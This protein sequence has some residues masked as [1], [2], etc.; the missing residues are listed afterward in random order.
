[1]C[2]V[3]DESGAQQL[4]ANIFE[5][6]GA[7]GRSSHLVFSHEPRHPRRPHDDNRSHLIDSVVDAQEYH[8]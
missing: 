3:E 6:S 7:S 5:A 1:M 2:K 4:S 8:T